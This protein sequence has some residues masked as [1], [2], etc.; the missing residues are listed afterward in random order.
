[1]SDVDHVLRSQVD[2][3]N[4]LVVQLQEQVG[5]V[6][7]QVNAVG[8]ETERARNELRQLR[9]EFLTFVRQAQLTAKVQLAQT[10][11][12]VVQ[13]RLDHEFGHHKQVRRTAVGM[14]QA[15]DTG[16]VSEEVVRNIS[17]ELMIQTPRYWLAPALVA[18][19]AWAADDRGLCDRA[20]EEAFR[21]SASR[22]SLFFAL[23][24]RRQGRREASVRWLRHYLRAQDP[25]ALGREFAVIL[26]S[27]SQGAFGAEGRELL[28]T[29]LV[30]WREALLGDE[31]ARAA[32]VARWREE[33]E[34]LRTPTST[35]E[36]ARLA[37]FSPQWAQLDA[38]LS[39]ARA[40]RAVIDK[41]TAMLAREEQPSDRLED[42]VDDILDRL[43]SEYDTEELPHRRELAY[44]EAVI[45]EGGDE[46]AARRTAGMTQAALEE[47]LD[48]LTVQ[49]ASAL[50]PAAIGASPATQRLSVAACADWFAEAHAGFSRDYRAAVPPDVGV[51]FTSQHA[52]GARTFALPPWQGS[53]TEPLPQLEQ[54]LAGHWDR[55]T[56]P[57]VDS[58]AYPLGRNLV[59]PGVAAVA[60]LF[61]FA[62]L[63]VGFAVTLALVVF[64]VWGGSVY[65][66]AE[67]AR[68]LQN[69]ARDTLERAKQESLLHLRGAC[70]ELSDWQTRYR[71]A[72]ALEGR[73][74]ALI[75]DLATAGGAASPYEGRVVDGGRE[76]TA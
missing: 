19:A 75:K 61:L 63:S 17:D 74:R 42:A 48:Y 50:T 27:I 34:A 67:K 66:K 45:A 4:R 49:T 31:A 44:Q 52:V 18:M 21:R 6:S 26:E 76:G 46:D 73:A 64:A 12:G 69:Q 55:H 40:H 71:E 10:R 47:T 32:Q 37:A 7:G 5:V 9:D 51:R 16:L 25:A 28:R 30:R 41:Y 36:F 11:I 8:A 13:D 56:A 1:M 54:S 22:T 62:Q 29:T 2:R 20:V 14:L 43:V 24:L 33:C 39:G 68:E 72:D 35:D 3:V 23:V 38:A 15:F 65:R 60:A 53:F 58:L 57:L 59:W 70:A